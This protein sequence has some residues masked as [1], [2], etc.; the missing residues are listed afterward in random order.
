MRQLGRFA[1]LYVDCSM[2]HGLDTDCVTCGGTIANKTKGTCTPCTYGSSFGTSATN[3]LQTTV[4]MAA[5]I[6]IFSQPI[7]ANY[8]SIL[9]FGAKGR[10]YFK[11]CENFRKCNQINNHAC[12]SGGYT[13]CNDTFI[14]Q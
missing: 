14:P 9:A 5:R 6:A 1:E 7:M 13:L 3:Q 4:Y 11:D 10:S 12:G 8:P 2:A